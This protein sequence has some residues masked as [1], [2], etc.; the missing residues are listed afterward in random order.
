[1]YWYYKYKHANS[2]QKVMQ[3]I[4]DNVEKHWAH[5]GYMNWNIFI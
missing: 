2:W 1:M 4:K 5:D 3:Q